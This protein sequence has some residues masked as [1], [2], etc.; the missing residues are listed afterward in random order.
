[1]SC[2]Q[3]CAL[4]NTLLW[5]SY[6]Y[7]P[8]FFYWTLANPRPSLLTWIGSS[9]RSPTGS[10]VPHALCRPGIYCTGLPT[11]GIHNLYYSLRDPTTLSEMWTHLLFHDI[12]PYT[13]GPQS[14]GP[15][16]RDSLEGN[17]QRI[18]DV[19]SSKHIR[20]IHIKQ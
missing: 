17:P 5:S 7:R 3:P 10:L 6:G 19:L 8:C 12:P 1:M 16:F 2:I 20:S 14:Y 9:D 13:R 15:L 18:A 11:R 4:S